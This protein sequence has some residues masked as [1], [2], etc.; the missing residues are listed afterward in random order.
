V[1]LLDTFQ[2]ACLSCPS[3]SPPPLLEATHKNLVLINALEPDTI[4]VCCFQQF[5]CWNVW[6]QSKQQQQQQ[7]QQQQHALKGH[8]GLGC[9]CNTDLSATHPRPPPPSRLILQ[10]FSSPPAHQTP[11]PPPAPSPLPLSSPLT[12]AAVAFALCCWLCSPAPSSSLPVIPAPFCLV[13]PSLPPNLHIE[14]YLCSL[15]PPHPSTGPAE[16][17]LLSA[18]YCCHCCHYPSPF[19]LHPPPSSLCPPSPPPPFPPTHPTCMHA[20]TLLHP[21]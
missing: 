5:C 13:P 1:G 17:P 4:G 10:Q 8:Q 19:P 2:R 16:Q 7:Q 3:S 6:L 15:P 14:H 18:A 11:P 20:S 21:R 9:A 12:P